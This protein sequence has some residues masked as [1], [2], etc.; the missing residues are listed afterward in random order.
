[1][2]EYIVPYQ[3]AESEFTE[4]RSRFITHL[5]KVET[6]AEARARIEEMKKKYYDARHNCW[7]YLLQEGGVVRYS[8]DGEPQGTAGQPMLNVFQRQEVWNVCCVVTRY[9]GGV[10]LGAGGLT[11]PIQRAR[12]GRPD[13]RR[14]CPDGS[15][16]AVGRALHLSAA[17]AD[18]AGVAATGGV[19]RDAEYGADITLRTAFPAGAA[20]TF[21][22]RLT[23]L[24]A[25]SLTM[26]AAGE[27]FLPGPREEAN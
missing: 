6:E 4:K 11:G 24:S 18:E 21:Q 19:V 5:Y 20:E 8:D 27:E 23:E 3:D 13:R 26:T 14:N 1:M 12:P 25:G 22:L 9:F 15:V 7:C 10:L 17:G 16:D 2:T